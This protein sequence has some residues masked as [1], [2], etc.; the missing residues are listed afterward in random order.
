MK[1]M[2]ADHNLYWKCDVSFLVD[3]FELENY[4]LFPSHCLS[5]QSL[6]SNIMLKMTKV[7]FQ[8]ILNPD[9]YTFFEKGT[10]GRK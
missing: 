8:L 10:R 2:K 5:A 6:S 7:A 1:T 4:G 9:M 3:V